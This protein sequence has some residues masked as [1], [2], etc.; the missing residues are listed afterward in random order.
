MDHDVECDNVTYVDCPSSPGIIHPLPSTEAPKQNDDKLS[1]VN[2]TY[3][4]SPP[5]TVMKTTVM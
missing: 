2:E 3:A 1:S 4:E 5:S